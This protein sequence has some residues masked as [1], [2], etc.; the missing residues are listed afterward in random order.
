MVKVSGYRIE[1]GEI[2]AAVLRHPDI[3]DA[4]V[5]LDTAGADRRIALYYTLRTPGRGPGLVALKRHCARF[6]PRY[7][8]PRTATRLDELPRNANGKTDYR[9]L[10]GTAG[11]ARPARAL[12]GR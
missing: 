3:A 4:A 12:P 11:A 8:L 1:L 2:E 10:S 9:R 7:M 6:L 5:V